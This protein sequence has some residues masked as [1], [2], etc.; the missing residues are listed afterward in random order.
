MKVTNLKLENIRCFKTA[1]IPFEN[2]Q[3]QVKNWSLIIGDNG[4]GKTTILRSLVLGLC[5]VPEAS[6]LLQ[7][8]HGGFLREGEKIGF[9]EITLKN[10]GNKQYKIKTTIELKGNSEIVSQK[11]FYFQNNEWTEVTDPSIKN[12]VREQIFI[13]GYGASRG[14]SGDKYYEEYAIIDSVYSLFNL[15][16]FNS[17]WL[18]THLIR[19]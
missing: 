16:G 4:Q 9:V 3:G 1:D 5:D 18:A 15:H 8:L 14:V 6:G 13:V 17:P 12:N 11:I 19:R 10:K 7:E 2:D